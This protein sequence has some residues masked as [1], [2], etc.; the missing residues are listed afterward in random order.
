MLSQYAGVRKMILRYWDAYGGISAITSSPYLHA[1]LLLTILMSNTWVM[2][3]WWDT[4]ISIMPNL[5]GF[6]LGGFAIIVTFGNDEFKQ[7]IYTIDE[8]DEHSFVASIGSTF[9][10]FVMLQVLA[11]I[12][13]LGAKSTYFVINEEC[14]LCTLLEKIDVHLLQLMYAARYF[15]WFISYCIFM[16]AL[17]TTIAATLAIYRLIYN[18]QTYINDKDK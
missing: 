6:T 13:A 17:T 11:L 7:L 16:Y 9:V 10:H 14:N 4:V 2:P 1:A 18:Y 3:N 5:T 8:T 15:V 12:L